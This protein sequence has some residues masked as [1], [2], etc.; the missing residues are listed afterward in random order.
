M[1]LVLLAEKNNVDLPIDRIPEWYGI[2]RATAQR[3]LAEL[4]RLG[5]L[6]STG[7]QKKAPLAPLGYTIE[8]RHLLIGPFAKADKPKAAAKAAAPATSASFW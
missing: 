8:R 4:L 7:V 6:E 3:G 1:L 5:L 2:S